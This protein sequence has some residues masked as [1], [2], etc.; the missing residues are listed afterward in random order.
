[1]RLKLTQRLP[2]AELVATAVL[3]GIGALTDTGL[4]IFIW[5][6]GVFFAINQM[7]SDAKSERDLTR[8]TKL[9]EI[10]DIGTACDTDL[11]R[12]VIDAYLRI[13]EPEFQRIKDAVLAQTRDELLRL[14]TQKSSEEL[15]AGAYYQWLISTIDNAPS[16]ATIIALSL[17]LP[18][19]WD[20]SQAER[21]FFE[22]NKRAAERG[23][24]IK[25]IFV[26]PRLQLLDACRNPAVRLHLKEEQP[27]NLQGYFVDRDWLKLRDAALAAKLGDGF[28]A[29]DRIA[30]TDLY[31]NG[32]SIRGTVTMLPTRRAMLKEIHQELMI[33]AEH[34]SLDLLTAEETAKPTGTKGASGLPAA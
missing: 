33:H 5:T 30:L 22:A 14:A 4:G 15:S 10:V 21:Y 29:F 26:A 13:P 16:G 20:D 11:L 25:R 27:A 17:M 28:I 8:V 32:G 12:Q 3:G 6:L 34:L 18:S 31:A 9:A 24:I 2:K 1:M 7:R 19:E 23:V